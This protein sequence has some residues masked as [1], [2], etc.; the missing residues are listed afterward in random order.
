MEDHHNRSDLAG[1]H[2]FGDMGQLILL[3]LF[4][5]VWITD[6]FFLHFSDLY[7]A[8][9]PLFV[10]IILIAIIFIMGGYLAYDGMRIVF[11]EVRAEPVVIRKGVFT[12]IRHPI[13]LG[14][15]LFYAGL[16]VIKLSLAA[17]F[18][19]LVIILFYHLIS[20]HEE[21]LLLNKFGRDYE[22]YMRDVPMWVPGLKRSNKG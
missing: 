21:K 18:I 2:I 6:S 7:T 4:M 22:Q 8:L 5:G 9:L 19:W 10:R 12:V 14:A 17:V 15:I 1:E 3:L 13:Y 16:L 11:G 20:R